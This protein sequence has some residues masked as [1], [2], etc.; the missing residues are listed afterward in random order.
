MTVVVENLR[1]YGL[2]LGK[3]KDTGYKNIIIN[4]IIEVSFSVCLV[5]FYAETA[6]LMDVNFGEEINKI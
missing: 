5:R 2:W 4:V 1:Y 3:R 6:E